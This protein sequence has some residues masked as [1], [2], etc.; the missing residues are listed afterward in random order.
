MSRLHRIFPK[1]IMLAVCTL[2]SAHVQAQQPASDA[3]SEEARRYFVQ[4]N[5]LFKT[6]QS[7]DDYTQAAALY[8][9]ALELSPHFGNAWYNLSKAQER[10]EQ[11]DDAI[12]SLKHFLADSP[13]DPEFR[14]M[15]NHVYELEVKRDDQA[16]AAT[17]QRQAEEERASRLRDAQQKLDAL[18]EKFAGYSMQGEVICNNESRRDYSYTHGSAVCT[19]QEAAGRNWRELPG[20]VLRTSGLGQPVVVTLAGDAPNLILQLGFGNYSPFCI[21]AQDY[22]PY[23]TNFADNQW[24][25]CASNQPAISRLDLA[26][27]W[28]NDTAIYTESCFTA[29]DCNYKRRTYY[30]LKR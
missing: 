2:G 15:Q 20:E 6:A 8:R 1:A 23:T 4:A 22:S 7:K 12:A 5:T 3:P 25:Y 26:S 21:K 9:Q 24:N 17:A 13:N 29:Q 28:E 19:E 18:R 27:Q 14:A 10:L 11:Y 30:V 16:R